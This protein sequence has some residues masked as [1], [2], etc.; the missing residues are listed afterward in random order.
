MRLKAECN[1]IKADLTVRIK[2]S[3][4]VLFCQLYNGSTRHVSVGLYAEPDK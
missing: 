2:T 3:N 1:K 4:Y